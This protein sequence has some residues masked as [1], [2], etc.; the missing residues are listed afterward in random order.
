MR[1]GWIACCLIV[2]CPVRA[3]EI[4]LRAEQAQR[5]G[6]VVDSVAAIPVASSVRLP[7]QVVVPPAQIEVMASAVPAMVTHLRVASGEAVKKGQPLLR[8]QGGQLPELQSAFL[9]A[10]TQARLAME[11]LRRDES[12]FA[13]GLISAGRLSETRAA[14]EQA[15]ALAAEKRTALRQAGLAE[16]SSDRPPVLGGVELRAPFDGVV[17]DTS[18]APGQRVDAMTPLVRL[19]RLAPL[20]LEI[21]ATP[22]QA[23]GIGPGD[24][25]RVPGCDAPAKITVVAPHVQAASQSLLIRAELARPK[26]CV[27]PFQFV[28]VE[29]A[30]AKHAAKAAW[31]VPA[32]AVVRHR[33]QNW[34]F[35]AE[36]EGFR[37][38]AVTVIDEAD[39]MMNILAELPDGARIAI[40]G[41]AALKAKWLGLGAQEG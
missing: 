41:A 10:Q 19:A 28:Q 16:P 18:V 15:Q 2:L 38:V 34:I 11:K 35:V 21:Q 40:R 31:R 8:L 30:P 33:E 5:M 7:A 32:T 4:P 20:W 36:A 17:L 6:V 22:V 1:K 14:A 39:G 26:G 12:L 25:V 29:I 3:A 27:K 9:A 24:G 23:R 13:E 37:P